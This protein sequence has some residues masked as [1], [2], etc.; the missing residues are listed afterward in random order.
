MVTDGSYTFGEHSITYRLTKSLCFTT[1]TNVT[2]GQLYNNN[3]N[4]N[5]NNN[6]R[7]LSI[8]KIRDLYSNFMVQAGG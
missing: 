8:L 4:N 7:S 5:N 2:L 3:N 1:E 6:M